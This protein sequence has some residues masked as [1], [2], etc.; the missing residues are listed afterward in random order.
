MPLLFCL[1]LLRRKVHH[2][3]K[4]NQTKQTPFSLSIRDVPWGKLGGGGG[5]GGA[6][7]SFFLKLV[8]NMLFKK[9]TYFLL[10][11]ITTNLVWPEILI[12]KQYII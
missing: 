10:I 9:F 7:W 11:I 4:V 5:G 6:Q 2:G 3:I 8:Q 12:E 1:N